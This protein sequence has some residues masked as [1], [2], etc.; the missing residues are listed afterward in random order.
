[1]STGDPFYYFSSGG[2]YSLASGQAVNTTN[3]VIATT[4]FNN[5]G[6]LNGL[7]YGANT[8]LANQPALGAVQDMVTKKAQAMKRTAKGILSKLREE[9]DGWHGDILERCPA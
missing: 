7:T 4:M 2:A 5:L 8:G 9:I 3:T 6:V 1:M